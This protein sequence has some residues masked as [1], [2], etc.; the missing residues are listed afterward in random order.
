MFLGSYRFDGD[1]DDLIPAYER[2]VAALPADNF[3][4]HVCAQTDDGL[5]VF[6]TCPSREVFDGFSASPAFADAVAAAGLPPARVE[7]IGLTVKV[8]GTALAT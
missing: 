4:L 1:V 3:E 8:L 7:P 6:D 5:V 2:L